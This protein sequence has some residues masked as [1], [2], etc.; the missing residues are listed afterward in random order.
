MNSK[1]F[2]QL[3]NNNTVSSKIEEGF[4]KNPKKVYIFSGNFKEGGFNILEDNFID[5]DAKKYIVIG[6][7]KKNTTKVMLDTLLKYTKDVYVYNNN[8]LIE[9]DSSMC[10]FEYKDEAVIYNLS[11]N[12][13]EGGLINNL[14][15]YLETTYDLS[16]TD[17]KKEY[18]NVVK[19]INL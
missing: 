13:S 6:I 17:D 19:S 12:F 3:N 11:S 7:D 18:K 15:F 16:D 8:E 2:F 5:S 10:I 1:M 4:E 9:F 14:S